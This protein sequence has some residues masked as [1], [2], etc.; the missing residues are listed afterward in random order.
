MLRICSE[1]FDPVNTK[2]EKLMIALIAS[3]G[4]DYAASLDKMPVGT[5]AKILAFRDGDLKLG[6]PLTVMQR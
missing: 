4:A 2:K 6:V 1:S 5:P 3:A